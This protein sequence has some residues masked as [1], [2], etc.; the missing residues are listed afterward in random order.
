MKKYI[1]SL[2]AILLGLSLSYAQGMKDVMPMSTMTKAMPMATMTKK[3]IT[4]DAKMDREKAEM[5]RRAAMKDVSSN[6]RKQIDLLKA[7]YPTS[8]KM[9]S[10]TRAVMKVEKK[11][12]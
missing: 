3:E 1:T 9:A 5:Q 8:T 6:T 2:F 10:P 12:T 11:D 4:Q 7:K